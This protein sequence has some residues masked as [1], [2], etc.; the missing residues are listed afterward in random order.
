MSLDSNSHPYLG[1][2]NPTTGAG[3]L[4]LPQA[5]DV[6]WQ[7]TSRATAALPAGAAGSLFTITG[8]RILQM[9]II[10]EVTTIIQTQLDNTKLQFNPTATGATTDICSVLDITADA[11][12]TL[13]S[14]T[15]TLADA[16]QEGVLMTLGQAT[17]LV[18]SEGTIDLNCSATNTGSIKWDLFWIPLDPG[19]TVAAA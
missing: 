3:I 18:L 10:G 11:V 8:G 14:I 2:S 6:A 5:G 13:Y 17:P 19:A 15:G 1:V 9:A 4:S 7:Q 16:L 12:G